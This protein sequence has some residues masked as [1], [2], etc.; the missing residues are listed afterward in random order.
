[1]SN[2]YL[3]SYSF[4]RNVN[5]FKETIYSLTM[6]WFPK[7]YTDRDEDDWNP[8]GTAVID[9]ELDSGQYTS[10]IFVRGITYAQGTVFKDFSEQEVVEWLENETGL[11]HEKQF[12][13]K[14][15][16]ERSFYFEECINGIPLSPSGGMEIRCDK[17]GKL[18]YFAINGHWPSLD[19][20]KEE[21]YTLTLNEAGT[22]AK[23]QLKR[24]NFPSHERKKLIPLY[25]LEEVYITNDGSATIP[26]SV[27]VNE[28]FYTQVNKQLDW[29]KE[30]P[31]SFNGEQIQFVDE[32]T[33]EE[34]LS[35]E[36]SI[37]SLPIT[38][39][40]VDK[41]TAA[42]EY[43]LRQVYPND[44]GKWVFL[45]LH[46]EHGCLVATLR[47]TAQDELV[48]Q[49][50][51]AVF[52]NESSYQVINYMDNAF[53]LEMVA[54][55]EVEGEVVIQKD[56]AYEKLKSSLELTPVYVYTDQNQYRLCGKLDCQY[57]VLAANGEKIVLNEL[58]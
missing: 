20:V 45:T 29:E 30:L 41:S 35:N 58:E 12:Q 44:S 50:K 8:P 10:V 22:L 43:F 48:F 28:R 40:N 19:L 39:E 34:A 38:K 56:E 17:G 5:I 7:Q 13:M 21:S 31:N 9:Y 14:K 37:D 25:A 42:V 36:P 18:T 1:M 23:E 46:R 32:V 15:A 6:E 27:L 57:S 24:L 53:F 2:Y 26:F 16:E 51:L 49:R 47:A 3:Y 4:Y 11:R 52:I 55:F 54:D 33:E